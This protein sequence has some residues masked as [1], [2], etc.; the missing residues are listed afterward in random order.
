MTEIENL[1]ADSRAKVDALEHQLEAVQ[2]ALEVERIVLSRFEAVP[3]TPVSPAVGR[4][5]PDAVKFFELRPGSL[6]FQAASILRK[7]GSPLHVKELANQ[8]LVAGVKPTGKTPFKQII[9]SALSRSAAF[10]RT[11]PSTFGL[12]EW[13]EEKA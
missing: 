4:R 3:R 13:V 9:V 6:A 12:A 5:K 1:I 7:T 11:A 8:L 10:A 2:H